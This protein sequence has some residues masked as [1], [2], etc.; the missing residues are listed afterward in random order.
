MSWT[1]GCSITPA[2]AGR[3]QPAPALQQHLWGEYPPIHSAELHLFRFKCLAFCLHLNTA[4]GAWNARFHV[5]HK[6]QPELSIPFFLPQTA[7]WY[8]REIR[9]R[10]GVKPKRRSCRLEQIWQPPPPPSLSFLPPCQGFF[11]SR[12]T[13]SLPAGTQV[14]F[15][16]HSDGLG[17]L[18]AQSRY[19]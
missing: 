5:Q 10:K 3:S 6:A 11:W 19:I 8:G 12:C 2:G 9:A 18:G 14:V 13:P 17:L 1:S 15:I 16:C 4:T 7:S